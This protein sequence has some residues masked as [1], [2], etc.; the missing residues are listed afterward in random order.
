MSA[1]VDSPIPV[2][3]LAPFH[4]GGAEGKRAVAAQVDAACRDL[5]FLQVVGHGVPLPVC[6]GLLN[7]WSAFFDL[8]MAE[9][10]RW[11]VP[12]ESA[13]RG[14]SWPGKEALAYSRGEQ[15]PP[16][17]MEAFNVGR[18]VQDDPYFE[19]HATFYAPTVWPDRPTGLRAAWESYDL[20]TSAGPGRPRPSRGRC[21]WAPTPTTASSPSCWPTTCP[22]CRCSGPAGGRTSPPPA[23]PSRSTSG[24]CWPCGPTTGGRR[25]CTGWSRPRPRPMG[26]CA[27]GRSPAS[28]TAS[29]TRSST[30]SRRA[31]A[32]GTRP[33]TSR[34]RRGSG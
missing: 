23:G 17:L 4:Q 26:R 6:D 7:A 20:A 19:L 22:G 2:V 18:R 25:R 9:K 33:G 11:V 16:D 13:N 3:D 8:P 29:P 1:P 28:S 31:A 21:G 15:T 5:G 14:Y 34:S 27:G 10:L 30:A 32:R 24:T 12:D